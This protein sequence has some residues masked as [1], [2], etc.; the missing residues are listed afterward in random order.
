V[1]LA[2]GMPLVRIDITRSGRGRR[3]CVGNS[4]G[5]ENTV[6]IGEVKSRPDPANSRA[7]CGER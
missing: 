3:A 2:T 5:S 6:S 4:A 1:L 7:L